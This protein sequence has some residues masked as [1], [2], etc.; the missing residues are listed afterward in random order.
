MVNLIRRTPFFVGLVLVLLTGC[1]NLSGPSGP[2]PT[3]AAIAPAAL[4]AGDTA[5]IDGGGFST[6]ATENQ[7]T[8]NG[9]A[10]VVLGATATR[11]TVE[12]PGPDAFPCGPAGEVT[13]A[14]S[15]GGRQTT[16]LHPAEGAI[17]WTLAPGESMAVH[18]SR[19]DCNELTAGG[20]YFIS[21]FNTSTTPTAMTA[22]RLRGAGAAVAGDAMGFD[23]TTSDTGGLGTGVLGAGHSHDR[24]PRAAGGF[25]PSAQGHA[26][27]LE[28]NTRLARELLARG[29]P[30]RRSP[31]TALM[32][33]PAEVGTLRAFRITDVDAISVDWCTSF[34][35]ITA[36]AVYSGP[37]AVI[38]EDTLAPLARQTDARWPELG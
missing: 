36:R 6:T 28:A 11:L 16:A 38:W 5:T 37:T 9:V 13:V 31:M 4:S 27:I 10:G 17:P 33:A 15:V 22:F 19:L 35:T 24:G 1:D 26:W 25:D 18:G 21:V 32:T 2:G 14:V 20:T 12:L 8:I 29:S 34:E 30:A 7:V 3:I 23:A